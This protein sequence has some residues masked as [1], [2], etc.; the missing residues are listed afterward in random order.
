MM[1]VWIRRMV[2]CG[3]VVTSGTA[4]SACGD[5]GG[6]TDPGPPTAYDL[7]IELVSMHVLGDCEDTDG[8]PGEINWQVTV[9]GPNGHFAQARPGAEFPDRS[10]AQRYHD[11]STVAVNQTLALTNV[12]DADVPYVRIHLQATEWDPDGPDPDMDRIGVTNTIS[13][14]RGATQFVGLG[15]YSCGLQLQYMPTWNAR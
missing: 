13:P 2:A 14:G 11:G 3:A 12:S 15:T 5:A 6:P 7:S 10:S 4:S 9:N 1:N 8:N